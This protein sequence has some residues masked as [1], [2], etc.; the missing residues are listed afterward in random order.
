MKHTATIALILCLALAAFVITDKLTNSTAKKIGVVQM[1]K[2]V[3]DFK[4]MKEA[5]EHYKNKL[6]QWKLQSDSMETKLKELYSQIRMDSL[7]RDQARLNKDINTFMIFKQAYA[8]YVQA[9]QERADRDDKQMTMGV[10]NQVN[11]YMKLYAEK[12]GYDVIF[13]NSTQQSIGYAK[14]ALDVTKDVLEFSNKQYEGV[15]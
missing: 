13:C 1:E 2:L 11:E 14:D 7:S 6:E 8:D 15:K 10:I 9:T 12:H 3:Y 5:T 4:G